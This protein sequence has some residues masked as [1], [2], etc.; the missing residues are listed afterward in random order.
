[1]TPQPQ[2]LIVTTPQTSIFSDIPHL[3]NADQVLENVPRAD[4]APPS[5]STASQE[6]VPASQTEDLTFQRNDDPDS[7]ADDFDIDI[8]DEELLMLASEVDKLYA[9]STKRLSSP[10]KTNCKNDNNSDINSPAANSSQRTSTMFIS[11]VTPRTRLLVTTN[12]VASANAQKPIVRP[13]FPEP[14]RDRSPII[15]LSSNIRLRTC[16]R[17]GEAINQSFQAA[18]S[19]YQIII[20]LYAR[21]LA[22]ERTSCEQ[23]FTFCDLFHVKPPYIMGGYTGAI[24]KPVQLFEYDGR[25]LLQQGRMCRCIGTMHRD[26]KEW[27]MTVLN[28]W[29]ATWEDIEWVEGIAGA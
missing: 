28:I 18:K 7:G 13:P 24:W 5:I 26:G 21:V 17:I 27:K 20:E 9:D 16:F 6:T 4:P 29:E 12:D 3:R 23:N 22:S 8:N 10:P 14:V 19:G 25:R 1:V 15:G 2:S 11:P